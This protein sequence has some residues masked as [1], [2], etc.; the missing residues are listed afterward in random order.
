MDTKIRNNFKNEI[1][2][3]VNNNGETIQEKKYLAS[4][5]YHSEDSKRW[6]SLARGILVIILS[7]LCDIFS[8]LG[9]ITWGVVVAGLIV[10]YSLL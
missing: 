3:F 4:S 10:G 9:K 8:F 6:G 2:N 5:I 7:T 1:L